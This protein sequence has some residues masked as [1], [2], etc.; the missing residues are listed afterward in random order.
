MLHAMRGYRAFGIAPH[1]G[2]EPF[3]HNITFGMRKM[4]FTRPCEQLYSIFTTPSL[5]HGYKCRF[6]L[7]TPEWIL[8]LAT[9]PSTFLP[10]PTKLK[11]VNGVL[12]NQYLPFRRAL[13]VRYDSRGSAFLVLPRRTLKAHAELPRCNPLPLEKNAATVAI[14]AKPA[15]AAKD[16]LIP[17]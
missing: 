8:H 9:L 13:S 10:N 6:L 4:T 1:S 17:L 16:N 2:N 14:N 3:R 5:I 15:D 11:L 12:Q 7:F